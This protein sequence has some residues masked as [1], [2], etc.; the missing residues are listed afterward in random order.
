MGSHEPCWL[1]SNL[2][3]T[4]FNPGT[5]F[6]KPAFLAGGIKD[7]SGFHSEAAFC[8]G[9]CLVVVLAGEGEAL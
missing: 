3:L 7:G 2:F 1:S 9:A 4:V 8:L 6:P 5:R